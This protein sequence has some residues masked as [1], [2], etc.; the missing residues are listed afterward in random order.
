MDSIWQDR[1]PL[2][3]GRRWNQPAADPSDNVP[4]AAVRDLLGEYQGPPQRVY[5]VPASAG[6]RHDRGL[7]RAGPGA[8]LLLLGSDADPDVLPHRDLRTRAS[9]LRSDQVL[10]L[11]V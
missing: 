7:L 4:H 6:N 3:D 5:G 1:H 8:V 2:S 11:H 9:H 10:S